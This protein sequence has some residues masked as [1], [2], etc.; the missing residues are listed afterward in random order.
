MYI[1]QVSN[2]YKTDFMVVYYLIILLNKIYL[3][4]INN[5]STIILQKYDDEY[6]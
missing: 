5:P 6:D 1:D 3:L 2:Y 4:F